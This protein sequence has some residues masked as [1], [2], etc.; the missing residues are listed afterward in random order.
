MLENEPKDV[1]YLIILDRAAAE[2][3]LVWNLV[4]GELAFQ[5]LQVATLGLVIAD[6]FVGAVGGV[7]LLLLGCLSNLANLLD[8][9]L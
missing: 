8:F 9:V 4:K 6:F 5:R 3:D 7:S 1:I 2:F